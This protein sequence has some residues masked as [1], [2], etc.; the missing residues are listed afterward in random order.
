MWRLAVLLAGDRDR[1]LMVLRSILLDGQDPGALDRVHLDRLVIQHARQVLG[2]AAAY[3]E[4]SHSRHRSI[5][6]L[7]T[8]HELTRQSLEAWVLA[9]VEGRQD[10]EVARAMDCSKTATGRFLA[11]ADA[12]LRTRI[13]DPERAVVDLQRLL[14]GLDADRAFEEA[15]AH[16]DR[17]A[18][19]R[20]AD[21]WLPVLTLM[22]F[23]IYTGLQLL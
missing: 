13:D 23:L 22:G 20:L 8:L 6:L 15:A 2:D 18:R 10:V 21:R 16:I 3:A 7:H 11:A 12:F 9:R 1:A 14:A 17:T 4:P 5:R 19:R